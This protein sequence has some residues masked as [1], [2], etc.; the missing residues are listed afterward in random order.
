MES[1]PTRRVIEVIE[2]LARR[3]E[4]VTRLT[5][6]VRELN[7]NQATACAILSE[8]CA[9]GWASRNPSDKTFSLGAGLAALS[10]AAQRSRPLTQALRMAAASLAEELE[11]AVSV[12]ERVDDFLVITAVFAGQNSSWSVSVG[13]RFPFAAPFGPAYAAWEPEHEWERWISRSGVSSPD[14]ITHL[15]DY[16]AVTRKRGFSVERMTDAV[17]QVMLIMGRLREEGI[18]DSMRGYASSMLTEITTSAGTLG[19]AKPTYPM[20]GAIAAPVPNH[21]GRVIA[22]LCAHPFQTLTDRQ[23]RRVGRQLTAAVD[24]VLAAC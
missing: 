16:L 10:E 12:S 15:Q 9:R 2:L 13:D 5:D 17:A 4:G 11:F 6:V 21:D 3:G 19:R 23:T 1:P 8:L 24:S 7:L 14:L 22:N 18:S 20:V